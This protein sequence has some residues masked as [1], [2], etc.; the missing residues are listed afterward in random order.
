M[1]HTTTNSGLHEFVFENVIRRY[2]RS[3]TR[4][5][6]L[7]AGPGAMAARLNSLD[8]DVLAVDRDANGFAA[9]LP[10]LSLDLISRISPHSL[11]PALSH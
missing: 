9:D 4:A 7:G 1:L 10:H 8:L 5:A 3:G 6:D 2:A 11:V